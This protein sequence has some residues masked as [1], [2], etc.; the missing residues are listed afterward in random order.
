LAKIKFDCFC[1]SSVG[2]T[3]AWL[4]KSYLTGSIIQIVAVLSSVWAS[5]QLTMAIP[6]VKLSSGY[7]MPM[8]GLGTWKVCNNVLLTTTNSF[9]VKDFTAAK[10][11]YMHH[12][13]EL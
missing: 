9:E 10:L 3:E 13:Q 6:S 12:L 5:F 1:L 7:T 8:F 4:S 2:K 11:R